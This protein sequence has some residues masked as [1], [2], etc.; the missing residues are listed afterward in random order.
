MK[1]NLGNPVLRQSLS[2]Y[3]SSAPALVPLEND[4]R[5]GPLYPGASMSARMR[6]LPLRDGVH[7]LE[8]LRLTGVN[9]EMD[10]IMR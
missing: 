3:L 9:D 10:F 4:I 7:K 8:K 1:L 5:C 2:H 6:F